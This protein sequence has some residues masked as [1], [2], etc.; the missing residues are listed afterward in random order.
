M[1]PPRIGNLALDH[2]RIVGR[3]NPAEFWNRELLTVLRDQAGGAEP[4]TSI[5]AIA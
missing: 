1:H 3:Y 5:T 2:V 4:A